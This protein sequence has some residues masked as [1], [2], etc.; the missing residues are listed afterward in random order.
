MPTF[1]FRTALRGAGLLTLTA[2][3]SACLGS[4]D[5]AM[6]TAPAAANSAITEAPFGETDGKAV[7]LFTLTNANGLV[8]KITNYGGIVTELH[9][10]DKS[11]K[12][13]DI[14]HGFAKLDDYLK[15]H[16]YFG[17][18]VGRVGNRIKNATFTLDG[19]T[20]KLAANNGAHHLHGGQK[21]WDKVVWDA[22]AQKSA[23]GPTLILTYTSADGEEGYPGTVQ[24]RV[25]Y[26]LTNNNELR[27]ETTATA[28]KAT[29]VNVVHHTYWNLGGTGSGSIKN[30]V[31]KLHATKY[32]PGDETLVPTGK[33]APVSGTPF[34]FSTGK[35]IGKDL[36]AAGGD[37]VGYDLNFVVDGDAAKLRPVAR[38][39]DPASGRV[40][41]LFADQPG[42]QFY[43]GNFMDGT[44]TGKGA[45]H[46][47]HSAFC[48]ETQQ[49]PDSINKPAWRDRV[50]LKPGKTYTHTMIHRFTAE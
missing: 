13:A 23:D 40:M 3:L 25:V 27:I 5:A 46:A 41:E 11:G 31:L 48:L 18:M 35:A 12:S 15:G 24:A 47:Q 1:C 43:T 42:V 49:F 16:P 39:K 19:K 37:P 50:V 8:A 22:K 28:D 14:V 2:A 44:T 38:V 7:K 26:T 10:P 29:P 9:V 20:Y 34:D 32:T 33:I 21:G 17:A 45:K 36:T 4:K 6:T 30:H